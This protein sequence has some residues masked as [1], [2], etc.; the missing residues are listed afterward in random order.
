MEDTQIMDL[1]WARDEEAI[2]ATDALYGRRLNALAQKLLLNREDAE[3]SVND[4]Y[5]KTWQ[6]LPPHRPRYFYAFLAAICRHLSLDRLDW[7][8][9]AKRKAE[10]VAL[11]EEMEVC[12]P[13]MSHDRQ[14]EGKEIG[15]ILDAF[16]ET[17]PRDSR[18]IFLRRF[19]YA[20]SI[21]EIAQRYGMSE[22][23]VKMQITRTKEK[24]RTYLKNEEVYL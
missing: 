15:R 11:T 4:T 12:I 7:K 18:L 19:W 22:S 1:Y 2:R 5:M 17:L 10:V 20:D 23:K 6:A 24:L 21:G 14:M 8:N 9:A 13:D 16:L 3:E